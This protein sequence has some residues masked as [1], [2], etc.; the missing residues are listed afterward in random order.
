LFGQ[1]KN[2]LCA[3]KTVNNAFNKSTD[4]GAGRSIADREGR[5]I[6]IVCI[7]SRKKKCCPLNDGKSPV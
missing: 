4:G 6:S 3:I 5:P 2:I 1:N 7:Y